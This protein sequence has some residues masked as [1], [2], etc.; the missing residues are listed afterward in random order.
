MRA[1]HATAMEEAASATEE[2]LVAAAGTMA[3]ALANPH[4]T[5]LETRK[6]SEMKLVSQQFHASRPEAFAPIAGGGDARGA[7]NSHGG[8]CV[9]HG[10]KTRGGR[11]GDGIRAGEGVG[12]GP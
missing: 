11:G 2:K 10:R 12:R 1:A 9:R 4:F 3:S 5:N 6:V 8:G 7:R